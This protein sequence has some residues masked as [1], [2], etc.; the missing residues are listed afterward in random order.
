MKHLLRPFKLLVLNLTLG[1]II[2]NSNVAK[3]QM[4]LQ[5]ADTLQQTLS[6]FATDSNMQ[7]VA[8]AVVFPDGSTW[9][10]TH[11]NHGNDPLTTDMLYD[12]GSNT[13]SMI[14]AVMLMM[15]EDGLLSIDDTLYQYISE[16]ENVPYGITLK[17]LLSMR[18]GL[19]NVTNH[20][21]FVDSVIFNNTSTFWHPD[22]LLA[23]FLEPL[24]FTAGQGWMY[25]NTNYILLGKVIEAV[26]GQP[27]NTV[28][29]NRLFSP[30]NLNNM[31]LE[32]YDTYSQIKT[33]AYMLSGNYQYPS[34]FYALMSSTWAAG[35]VVSTPDDFASYC[36]QLLR[37]DLL[38]PAAF[39]KI[40]TGT[41]FG[42]GSIYGL[43]VER[44]LYNDRLYLMHGGNTVQ[45]S[46]MH[47]S[48]ESDFSVVVM[49][50]DFTYY[51]ETTNLQYA[52]IDVLEYAVHHVLSVEEEALPLTVSAYP[53][54][55]HDQILIDLPN[56]LIGENVSFE[57]YNGIGK[58]VQQGNFKN[59]QLQLY[60][61]DLGEGMFTVRITEGQNVLGNQKVVFY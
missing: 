9:S 42:A 58:L 13:K 14:A 10:S 46:E 2:I 23:E 41:N 52:L 31:Y 47:Y 18:S 6:N 50:I 27:L 33:G 26:E 16:V 51:S 22:S 45:N 20:P 37:G 29:Y 53:N 57:I 55:S 4:S 3:A 12:I 28:L 8:A 60:K 59:Q 54:P 61:A 7:G 32:T 24:V 19:A 11:G 1:V 21:D 35:G 36:H 49:D 44:E 5:F 25:S 39:T 34:D 38:S 30:F 48:L 17:Q 40:K 43:G 15:E 56:E